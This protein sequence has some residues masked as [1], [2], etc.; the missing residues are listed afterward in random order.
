MRV[1]INGRPAQDLGAGLERRLTVRKVMEVVEGV[2]LT[3]D[4]AVAQQTRRMKL[5]FGFVL[6]LAGVIGLGALA[7]IVASEPGDLPLVAA[8]FVAL[9]AGLGFLVRYAYRASVVRTRARIDQ[10]SA[11]TAPGAA[12]RV[13]DTGL[14]VGTTLYAWSDLALDEVGVAEVSTNEGSSLYI[15]R[16]MLS[17]RGR[18]ID[19][20]L[21]A[22]KNG[23]HI[24]NQTW[25]RMRA[26]VA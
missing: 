17:S 18:S 6:G 1:S 8:I 21:L 10:M 5:I 2:V 15:D 20:D 22:L 13:D 24:L 12:V 25:R 14:T 9:G 16:L 11:L 7:A 23:R 19:L 26:A 3:P 4:E